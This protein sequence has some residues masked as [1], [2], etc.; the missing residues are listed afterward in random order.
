MENQ[1]VLVFRSE[2]YGPRPIWAGLKEEM[3]DGI[4]RYLRSHK[5]ITGGMIAVHLVGENGDIKDNIVPIIITP[6]LIA[7]VH[8]S[9]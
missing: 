2:E 9:R 4:Y 8:H 7:K 3:M 5:K 6:E 1:V